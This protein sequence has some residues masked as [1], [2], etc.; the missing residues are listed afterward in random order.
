M[1]EAKSSRHTGGQ[2][3]DDEVQQLRDLAAHP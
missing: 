2:W 1:S 3:A